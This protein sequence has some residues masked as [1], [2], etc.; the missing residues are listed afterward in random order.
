VSEISALA[1]D[2]PLSRSPRRLGERLGLDPRLAVPG[3]A[4]AALML[5]TS[6]LL[7]VDERTL[8]GVSVWVKPLKFQASIGLYLVTLALFVGALPARVRGGRW[9][10]GLVVAA[11][12]TAAFEVVYITLQAACGLASHY[13]V[14]DP[15]HRTM[16][17]LMGVGAVV[18]TGVSPAVGALLWRHRPAQWSKALWIGAVSGLVLTFFL[19]AGTGGVLSP[20]DGH[21][22]GG[23]RTDLGGLPLVGWSRTGGDLRVA[24]FIGMHALQ[25]LPAIGW[26]AGRLLRPTL[27]MAATLFAAILYSLATVAALV[28]ALAGLPL[29]PS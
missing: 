20:R 10:T 2:V 13:N 17:G 22:V 11:L 27:A 29:L 9:V 26:I 28:Q 3:L 6:L 14:G 4:I 16:Y 15:F 1:A 23:L 25:V 12:A 8:N 7:L 18:L 19:G 24:H 21:W 5:P